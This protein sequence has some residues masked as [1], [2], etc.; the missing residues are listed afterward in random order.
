MARERMFTQPGMIGVTGAT[1]SSVGESHSIADIAP[2]NPNPLEGKLFQPPELPRF[3]MHLVRSLLPH[4]KHDPL[5]PR[6][7]VTPAALFLPDLHAGQS[8]SSETRYSEARPV[9]SKRG[10]PSSLIQW[11]DSFTQGHIA[12]PSAHNA[13]MCLGAARLLSTQDKPKPAEQS[14]HSHQ[15]WAKSVRQHRTTQ[16]SSFWDLGL[17]HLLQFT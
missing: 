9:H 14:T 3:T 17:G 11:K 5:S 1:W 16:A 12:F 4:E 15:P 7:V 8:C 2:Q 6:T 13:C 10:R